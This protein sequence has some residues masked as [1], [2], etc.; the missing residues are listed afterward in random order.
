LQSVAR[1]GGG[2]GSGA[3]SLTGIS[4]PPG[5]V[6][7]SWGGRSVGRGG[8]ESGSGG[9]IGGF[10][11][12]TGIG[13]SGGDG[14]ATPAAS[15]PPRWQVLIWISLSRG[16]NLQLI[17]EHSCSRL[18]GANLTAKAVAAPSVLQAEM[19]RAGSFRTRRRGPLTATLNPH[20]ARTSVH[21][22]ACCSRAPAGAHTCTQRIGAGGNV[23]CVGERINPV[24]SRQI[25]AQLDSRGSNW[26]H[27]SELRHD[28]AP[29]GVA[30]GGGV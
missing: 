27:F 24:S 17:A 8:G 22:T 30:A 12:G 23:S 6:G 1:V 13:I 28:F 26:L 10:D 4:G 16:R 9:E 21:R 2:K 19:K 29:S 14:G 7:V 20:Q 18:C 15:E 25:Y 5:E 11:G 3:G